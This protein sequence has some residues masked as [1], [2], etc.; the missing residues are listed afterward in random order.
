MNG[1]RGFEWFLALRY[2]RFHRGRTFVSAI[3]LI[4]VAGVAVGTAAL[5]IALAVNAGFVEDARA[6]I[7]SGSAHLVIQNRAEER[8]VNAEETMRELS[9]AEGVEAVANVLRTPGLLY[10]EG[11]QQTAFAD[12]WGILPETHAAVI[13]GGDPLDTFTPLNATTATGRTPILLGRNLAA[14]LGVISGDLV[15]L[16]IPDVTLAPWGAQPRSVVFEVAGTYSSDHFQEDSQR[17][18]VPLAAARK[19]LRAPDASS[20]IELRLASLDEIATTKEQLHQQLGLDW[21]VFDLM[22]QNREFLKAL[23]TEKLVLS[24]AI[25]LIVI[26]AALNIVSML[27]LMVSDKTKEI[28]ALTAIG[29][30]SPSIARIFMIQGLIIG[31]I[32]TVTG[33]FLG[34]GLATIFDRYRLFKLNPEVYYLTHLPFSVHLTDLL[35]IGAATMLIS[36][37]ATLYPA[38]RA[39]GLDPVDALRYE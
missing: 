4:S 9:A 2:L 1:F 34:A 19:M 37:L 38:R 33:L 24:L 10:F 32:G 35:A 31:G 20:R 7:H 5:V 36:F 3:T 29:A 21:F 39:A 16:L 8:F 22:D 6:R 17:A 14:S 18:Y 15:R 23:N 27:I 12:V 28:G 11:Q 26:V 30:T 13:L 25:G